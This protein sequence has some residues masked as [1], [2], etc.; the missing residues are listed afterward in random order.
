MIATIKNADA[1]RAFLNK[2]SY[3]SLQKKHQ[4]MQIPISKES[5]KV[6]MHSMIDFQT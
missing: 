4:Q 5:N 6:E 3:G 1:G 2:V